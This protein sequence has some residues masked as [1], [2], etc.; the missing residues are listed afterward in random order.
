MLRLTFLMRRKQGLSREEM[1]RYWLE[2]HAPIVAG[3]SRALGVLRYVQ[4]HTTGDDHSRLTG[5][6]GDMEEP[7]DGVAEVWWESKDAMFAAT[8]S[9]EGRN[10][11]P[12]SYTHLTLPTSDLV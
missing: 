3:H 10:V 6:R 9:E 5:R 4:A 12:V 11:D 8:R 7:Y 2:K 1:Q